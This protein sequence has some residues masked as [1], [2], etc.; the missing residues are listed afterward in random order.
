MFAFNIDAFRLMAYWI[1]FSYI[2]YLI[3]CNDTIDDN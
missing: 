3:D 1:I 2:W